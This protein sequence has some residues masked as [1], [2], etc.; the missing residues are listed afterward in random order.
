[1]L[2]ECVGRYRNSFINID[3]SFN[4]VKLFLQDTDIGRLLYICV[5]EELDRTYRGKCM[6]ILLNETREC[7]IVRNYMRRFYVKRTF[8]KT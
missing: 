6:L 4:P 3:T 1:M 5:K 7:A 2:T 8:P